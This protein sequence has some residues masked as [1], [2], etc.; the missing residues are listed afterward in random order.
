MS[1]YLQVV[2]GYFCNA[3]VLFVLHII[4]FCFLCSP[5]VL[6]M[7]RHVPLYRAL[8]A[9]VRGLS[10]T[11][12]LAP[13][14][15][16][17]QNSAPTNGGGGDTTTL[18]CV[19]ALLEKMKTTVNTYMAKLRWKSSK[20]GGNSNGN[21][22]NGNN[23]GGNNNNSGSLTDDAEQEEGL[24]LIVPD[25]QNT[26]MVVKVSIVCT[27]GVMSSPYHFSNLLYYLFLCLFFLD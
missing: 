10:V 18:P 19:P 23:N 15:L 14:L 8:L 21:G 13:L 20:A 4:D 1:F 26:A 5:K 16:T 3:S 24:S 6:D 2:N 9:L 7:S 11:P 27:L 17:P 22:G 25:I 12:G